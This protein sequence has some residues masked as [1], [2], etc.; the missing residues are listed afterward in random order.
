MEAL[1]KLS[2]IKSW[3]LETLLLPF[4]RSLYSPC[5]CFFK[6][7]LKAT[8]FRIRDL[9]DPKCYHRNMVA[10]AIVLCSINSTF[11]M[12]VEKFHLNFKHVITG[13]NSTKIQNLGHAKL[14][15]HAR[16]KD[17]ARNDAERLCRKLV[18]DGILKEDL[19]ITAQDHAV[20]YVRLGS[21][22]IDLMQNKL[23]VRNI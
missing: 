8:L 21:R 13:S 9:S 10:C 5:L 14:A 16:G 6:L 4:S 1:V 22:A 12:L 2:C 11:R 17:W 18:I 20:C 7:H 23:K 15:L 19:Q 3:S